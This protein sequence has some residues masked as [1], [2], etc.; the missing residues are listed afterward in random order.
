MENLIHSWEMRIKLM[1]EFGSLLPPTTEFQL[2]YF[3]CKQSKFWLMCQEDLNTMN[4][5]IEKS[6]GSVMLWCDA[7]STD[8]PS[9][10]NLPWC[11]GR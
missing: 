11:I 6:K 4:K 1:D 3:F 2:G 10:H 9:G 5:C 7:R 8:Q